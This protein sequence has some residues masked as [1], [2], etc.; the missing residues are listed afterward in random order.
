MVKNR[1]SGRKNKFIEEID[2][3]RNT[4]LIGAALLNSECSN[5]NII[6]LINTRENSELRI[7]HRKGYA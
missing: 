7:I 6:K 4:Y 5:V 3:I 1:E 2:E